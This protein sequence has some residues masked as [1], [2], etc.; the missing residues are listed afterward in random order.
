MKN[1]EKKERK[2]AEERDTVMENRNGTTSESGNF[3]SLVFNCAKMLQVKNI[4]N[5][6]VSI[7]S[8]R[9]LLRNN[10]NTSTLFFYSFSA[11][12]FIRP[13]F[14]KPSLRMKLYLCKQ[15]V[16]RL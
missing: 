9:S 11:A 7:V 15:V 14:V 4:V 8:S 1:D 10:M 5:T 6:S 16:Y 13:L 12:I 3:L 2:G